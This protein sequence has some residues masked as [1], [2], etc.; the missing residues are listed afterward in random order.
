M[1]KQRIVSLKAPPAAGLDR[2][3]ADR[4]SPGDLERVFLGL[5]DRLEQQLEHDGELATN[6]AERDRRQERSVF[7]R[8][9]I[10]AIK[11]IR[12]AWELKT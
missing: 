7:C 3:P 10:V 9:S 11:Q 2:Q 4:L 5:I 12:Y 1:G 8:R 6:R